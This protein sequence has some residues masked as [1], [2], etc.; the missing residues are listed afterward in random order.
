M[1]TMKITQSHF[2]KRKVKKLREQEKK[3]LDQQIQTIINNPNIGHRKKGALREVYIYKF[4]MY[5]TQY[6]LAY[7]I[8]EGELEL[9]MIGSHENYYRDLE[10]YLK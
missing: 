1:M 5:T 4:K 6:L 10:N 9:I 3:I 7:R 8:I 2:F